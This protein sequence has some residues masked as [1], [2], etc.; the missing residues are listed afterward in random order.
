M[1]KYKIFY[2]HICYFS[3]TT[4]KFIHI[5]TLCLLHDMT[6]IECALVYYYEFSLFYFC[7]CFF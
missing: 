2:L 5:Y 4:E 6:F 1:Q 3:V 7:F